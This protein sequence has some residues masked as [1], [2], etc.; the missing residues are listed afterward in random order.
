MTL[1]AA[2]SPP[3]LLPPILLPPDAPVGV[4]DSGVGGLSVLRHIHALLPHEDLLY[5]ADSAFNPYGDK[6]EQWVVRRS[7]LIAAF[8]VGRGAKALVV[9]CNT[10]TVAAIRELRAHYPQLP[11]VGVEPGLKPAAAL[12]RSGKVGVL[13]TRRTLATEKF[14]L[15]R[16]QVAAATQVE[17]LLQGCS[18]LADQ[19]EKGELDSPATVAMLDGF[20]T[21]LL[22]QGADTLV[23]GSTHYP[24]ARPAIEA[25]VARAM[26]AG[27]VAAPVALV[28]T[29]EAVARQLQRLL[30][31]AGLLRLSAQPASLAGYTSAPAATLTTAFHTLLGLNAVVEEVHLAGPD[32]APA[33]FDNP[34]AS[35]AVLSPAAK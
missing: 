15:L 20:I 2:L 31:A 16:D 28:D 34:A 8:L 10:A 32:L 5:F 11:I 17:F 26:A 7:L 4:F 18:G 24:F 12:T 9:A 1:S 21:P 14:L 6:S 19:V 33:A 29:G 13:A 22:Q 3:V 27:T 35:T 30:L 23:L 25:L